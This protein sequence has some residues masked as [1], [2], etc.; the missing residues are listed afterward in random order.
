MKN[1]K[2]PIA[3]LSLSMVG[4]LFSIIGLIIGMLAETQNTVQQADGSSVLPLLFLPFF[5]VLTVAY[6]LRKPGLKTVILTI[7]KIT[8]LLILF[9]L[10][11]VDYFNVYDSLQGS[12]D[13]EAIFKFAIMLLAFI[14]GILNLLYY[15]F[16]RSPNSHALFSLTTYALFGLLIAYGICLLVAMF[17]SDNYIGYDVIKPIHFALMAFNLA[18]LVL[19]PIFERKAEE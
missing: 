19:L 3:E 1:K 11:I 8:I 10:T 4:I 7:L 6:S 9:I 12:F 17:V 2:L 15:F 18:I 13:L 5:L 16:R 14:V